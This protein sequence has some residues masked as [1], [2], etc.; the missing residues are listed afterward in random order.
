MDA[1][2]TP[3]AVRGREEAETALRVEGCSSPRSW[4]DA[5]GDAYGWHAHDHHKVLFCLEGSIVFHT[6]EG[7]VD[8]EAGDRL[9]LPPETE[10]AATVGA[11]GVSCMEASR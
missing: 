9:D 7:D 8:L 6:R 4:S 5:P 1:R 3:G 2:R 11:D 10:H